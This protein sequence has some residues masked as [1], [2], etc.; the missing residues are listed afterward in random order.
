MNTDD[1]RT[2]S[3]AIAISASFILLMI[4]ALTTNLELVRQCNE[5][6]GVV[7]RASSVLQC[8][9]LNEIRELQ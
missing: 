2:V 8:I 9:P 5:S 1:I 4:W 7:I 3:I 6:G